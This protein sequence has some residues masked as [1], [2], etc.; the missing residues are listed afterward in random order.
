MTETPGSVDDLTKEIACLRIQLSAAEAKLAIA[1]RTTIN[2][3]LS[4]ADTSV[5]GDRVRITNRIV[6][7]AQYEGDRNDAARERERQATVTHTVAAKIKT[8]TQVWFLTDNDTT[9]WRAPKHLERVSE[10]R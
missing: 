5:S 7:P 8:P 1:K 10:R 4:R 6:R 3:S 2:E 9:T